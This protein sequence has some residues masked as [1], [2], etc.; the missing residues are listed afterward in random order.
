MFI[1]YLAKANYN[2]ELVTT[3]PLQKFR[4]KYDFIQI[5][6]ETPRDIEFE[7]EEYTFTES[8]LLPGLVMNMSGLGIMS[9]FM[10]A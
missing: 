2:L 4:A 8:N 7:D 6:I 3:Y 5:Q 9:R 10:A 1:L